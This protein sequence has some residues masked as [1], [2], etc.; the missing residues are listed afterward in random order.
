VVG[1]FIF[2]DGEVGVDSPSLFGTFLHA[3]II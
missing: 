1:V 2:D 3:A